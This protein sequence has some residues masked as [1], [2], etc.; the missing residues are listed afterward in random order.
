MLKG[1]EKDWLSALRIK[2]PVIFKA[3]SAVGNL[4]QII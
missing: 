2:K 1:G 4:E 3:N